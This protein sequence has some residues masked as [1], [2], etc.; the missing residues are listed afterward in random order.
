MKNAFV[1]VPR[2]SDGHYPTEAPHHLQLIASIDVL[3]AMS[4]SLI[5]TYLEFYGIPRDG[6]D[7][8][9]GQWTEEAK[10]CGA[11]L[12]LKAIGSPFIFA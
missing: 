11:N 2:A 9:R 4:G 6:F 5:A 12:I 1:E 10:H 3:S 8:R 7:F